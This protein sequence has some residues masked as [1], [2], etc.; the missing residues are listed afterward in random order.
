MTLPK[1]AT[2]TFPNEPLRSN[3]LFKP[4]KVTA[5]RRP[6]L[7][8]CTLESF[9]YQVDPFIGCGHLCSYCYVLGQAESD[10]AHEI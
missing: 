10:W 3:R 2:M 5:C 8:P 9:A 6:V 1:E 7:D 4:K